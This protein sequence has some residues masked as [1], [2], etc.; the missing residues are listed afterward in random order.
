MCTCLIFDGSIL[1]MFCLFN[2]STVS[3]MARLLCNFCLPFDSIA[4]CSSVWLQFLK[5]II[6]KEKNI[7]Y[8]NEDNH[9]VVLYVFEWNL[10]ANLTSV[11]DWVYNMVLLFVHIFEY[12]ENSWNL[13][14]GHRFQFSKGNLKIIQRKIF[15]QSCF[16]LISHRKV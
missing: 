9:K 7:T 12:F 4:H 13:K 10:C 11:W 16:T 6:V 2:C 14:L 15:N 5:L 1:N 8:A 3:Q